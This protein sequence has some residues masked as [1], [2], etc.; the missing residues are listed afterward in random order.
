MRRAA[1]ACAARPASRV[2]ASVQAH[3]EGLPSAQPVPAGPAMQ[4]TARLGSDAVTCLAVL[5]AGPGLIAAAYG[6]QVAVLAVNRWAG[7]GWG[8]AAVGFRL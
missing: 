4:L 7:L 5:P 1:G 2:Q 6:G 3:G 8:R